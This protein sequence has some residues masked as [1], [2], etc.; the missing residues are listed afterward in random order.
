MAD[1]V[2]W[3][4]GRLQTEDSCSP[5]VWTS[6]VFN[7]EEWFPGPQHPTGGFSSAS[8]LV[9]LNSTHS[10]YTGGDPTW[11]ASWLYD[12]TEG[13]WAQSGDLNQGRWR[14]G[15]GVLEGQGVLVVGGNLY[16]VELYEPETGTWTPQPG[17]PQDINPVFQTL[18][19]SGMVL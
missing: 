13:V 8:C 7:G 4:A 6:E 11:T 14:H 12:W 2:W 3:V 15:C 19:W 16:T 18:P 17:F 5:D 10:L 9:Q 1:N